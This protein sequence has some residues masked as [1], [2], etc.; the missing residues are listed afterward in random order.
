MA[1]VSPYSGERELIF[2]GTSGKDH[3]E[4]KC[5]KLTSTSVYPFPEAPFNPNSIQTL[6]VSGPSQLLVL[7]QVKTQTYAY[8]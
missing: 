2:V 1:K 6:V 8:S 3:L 7:S 5:D 4:D